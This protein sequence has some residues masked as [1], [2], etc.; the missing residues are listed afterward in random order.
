MANNFYI[1]LILLLF[2]GG[3]VGW[4]LFFLT[5]WVILNLKNVQIKMIDDIKDDLKQIKSKIK[6]LK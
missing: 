1:H 3:L 5:F 6:D 4:S 2:I